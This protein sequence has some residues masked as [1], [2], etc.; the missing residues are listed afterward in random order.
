MTL[1]GKLKKTLHTPCRIYRRILMNLFSN[2]GCNNSCL[3]ILIL[4][5]V[6]SNYSDN[7][8]EGV[9]SGSCTPVL[10]ALIYT[11]WKNGTLRNILGGC[12][13][14]CGC[15][16]GC[17]WSCGSDGGTIRPSERRIRRSDMAAS[18]SS[19]VTMTIVWPSLSRSSKKRR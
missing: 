5:L 2:G 1:Q 7:G 11:M 8:I 4:L 3:W 6:A 18:C 10:I 15:G 12:G 14:G 9:L 16:W 17:G 19:W 13:C